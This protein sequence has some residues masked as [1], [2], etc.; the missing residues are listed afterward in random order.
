MRRSGHDHEP[1]VAEAG[2]E[3]ACTVQREHGVQLSREHERGSV[4]L[5]DERPIVG[6]QPRLEPAIISVGSSGVPTRP[7]PSN[8]PNAR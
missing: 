3:R 7:G 2:R 8:Q 5:S 6:A 4:D 1:S